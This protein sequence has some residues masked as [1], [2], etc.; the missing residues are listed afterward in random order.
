MATSS[1]EAE[2]TLHI[3]FGYRRDIDM[4]KKSLKM[5]SLSARGH[6]AQNEGNPQQLSPPGGV[7]SLPSRSL[8]WEPVSTAQHPQGSAGLSL[9][10]PQGTGRMMRS[11]S[12]IT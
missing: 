11:H 2:V 6:S 8:S 5:R 3:C 7:Q 4:F 9:P 1:F 10:V 12:K